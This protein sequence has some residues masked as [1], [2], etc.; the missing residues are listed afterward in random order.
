M[1]LYLKNRKNKSKNMIQNQ[2]AK[3][4]RR[5]NGISKYTGRIY[6]L[7]GILCVLAVIICAAVYEPV[8]SKAATSGWSDYP[9]YSDAQNGETLGDWEFN[10]S[11]GNGMKLGDLDFIGTEMQDGVE[12][13][14]A[15]IKTEEQLNAV[16]SGLKTSD[17]DGHQRTQKVIF[18]LT[19]DLSYS[20]QGNVV[21]Q[22][23]DMDTGVALNEYEGN[24]FEMDTFD[25][26]G[27]IIRSTVNYTVDSL[28]EVGYVGSYYG[29]FGRVNNATV[30]DL[31]V[32]LAG[33]YQIKEEDTLYYPG[34]DWN[35]T[36]WYGTTWENGYYYYL[37]IGGVCGIAEKAQ[38]LD[39]EVAGEY[40]VSYQDNNSF[41]QVSMLGLGGVLGTVQSDVTIKRCEDTTRIYAAGLSWKYPYDGY[42]IN[43]QRARVVCGIGG[44][45][46]QIVG[47]Y[48]QITACYGRGDYSYDKSSA[49]GTIQSL[50]FISSAAI[51]G[52]AGPEAAVSIKDCAGAAVS[53]SYDDI[54]DPT[55]SILGVMCD[56]SP[57][58]ITIQNCYGNGKKYEGTN[59]NEVEY[60][61]NYD[62]YLI[63]QDGE[64]FL[65]LAVGANTYPTKVE[66]GIPTLSSRTESINTDDWGY[67]GTHYLL[68]PCKYSIDLQGIEFSDP[69]AGDRTITVTGKIDGWF[70]DT[71]TDKAV[72]YL[73]VTED[74]S[75]PITS[76]THVGSQTG[77]ENGGTEADLKLSSDNT[78]YTNTGEIFTV[79]ARLKIVFDANKDTEYIWWSQIYTRSYE[80]DELFIAKPTLEVSK[81]DQVY[82]EMQSTTAYPLGTTRVKL[83]E[84]GDLTNQLLYYYFG[85]NKGMELGDVDSDSTIALN[86]MLR[87]P[88]YDEPFVIVKDMVSS[89]NS[90]QI[91]MY[92]LAYAT[93]GDEVY[94][95]L[96]E[97]D[98]VVFASDELIS[99]TPS[100][101]SKIPNGSTITFKI[102][103]REANEYPYDKVNVLISKEQN[104]YNT[105]E[106]VSGVKI[107]P[108]SDTGNGTTDDPF[109][110]AEITLTGNAGQTFYVYVEPCVNE[111][112]EQRYGSFLQEYT[113][114]IM[115][116]A[117]GPELSPSTIT[118]SQAGNPSSISIQE[119]IYMNSRGNSDIILYRIV[120]NMENK[121]I[122]PIIVTD[123]DIL[124]QLDAAQVT[125]VGENAY[126]VDQNDSAFYVRCNNIWYFM[127]NGNGELKVYEDGNLSFDASHA[128]QTAYVSVLLFAAGYDPSENLIYAYQVNEQDAVAAPTALLAS[129]SS[130]DMN[131]VLNFS[132]Q[133]N[134][135][136]FYTTNGQEP[137]VSVDADGKLSAETENGTFRYYSE[138]GIAATTENGFS[139]GAA[140][141]IKIKAYPVED[142]TADELKYNND[143]KSSAL[144]TFTYTVKEQN[145]VDTPKV[146][147]ETNT[148][149]A[150][151]VVNGDHIS[152]TC[153]TSGAEIYYTVN[154]STPLVAEEYKYPGVIEVEGDYGSY[155]TVKAMAHKEGMKDSEVATYLYKIADKDVVSGVTAI[156][157]TTNQVIAGDKIILSTTE[158]GADIYF[159]TDGTTPDVTEYENEDGTTAFTVIKGERYDPAKPVTV[160]EGSGYFMINAIA[161]KAGMTNSPVAQLIYSYADSVGVPYG[162]PSSGTVIENTQVILRCAQEDAI[163]YYEIAYDGEEPEEPT[164][165]S[166][167]FSEQA[168]IIITRDTKI[169]AFAFY[170]RESSEIVTLSYTL[171][172]K[173]EAPTSSVSSGAIVPSG[174][175][176]CLATGGGKVY[177]TTDGSDPTDSTNTAVN[178]GTDVVITG[179]PGDKIVIKAC[180]KETGATTSEM[181]TFTYQISQYPGGVATDTTVGSTL[182]G[183]TA[184]HL[185][186]DVT[187]GTIYHTTG[188]GS[189]ITAGTVG[190]SV[191]LSGEA[192]SNITV[193]AVA[194]APNTTMTG[195]Y[196]SFDYKLM[197]QL[198]AP[199]ASLKDGTKLTEK[200]SIVLKANKGKIYFTI[201]G[202]D[203]TKASN[204]YTA[205]IVVSKAMTI[206]AI[207]IEEGSENS[208][209]STFSY[210]FAEKV[211]NITSSVPSGTVVQS[212]E[213][214]KLN[215][216]TKDA[217]IYYTTDGTEPSK[218]GEEGVFVYDEKEGI[219][220]YRNVNIKAIAVK[221]ELCDSDILSLDYRVEEVPVEIAREKAAQEEEEAG[222][223]PSDITKLESRR[224]QTDKEELSDEY[225]QISDFFSNV[226]VR[227]K[228][229]VISEEST[230]RG[231]EIAVSEN[232]KKEI[233]SMLG[234]DYELICNYSFALYEN[235]ER[236]WPKGLLEI[237][238]PIPEEYENADVT[239]I[240]INEND[241]VK[242][243]STRREN[244]YVYAEV[245]YLNSYA[246]AGAKLE[247]DRQYEWNLVLIMS[248]VA[249]ALV[250]VG[251][252]MI[253]ITMVRRKR[254]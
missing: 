70:T 80:P 224:I 218:D 133:Q 241:G 220:I 234:D 172:Q 30:R 137:Q 77:H 143:K 149:N 1:S 90:N 174:T 198:A 179:K 85:K 136:M 238:I 103:N 68:H 154:G 84:N 196:A 112:Y 107:Y 121:D 187:G 101:G 86:T 247:K 212:G 245:S 252:G 42:G 14:C 39:I 199:H 13:P 155:F 118:M 230:L 248:V 189:P 236:T 115:D 28:D 16:L 214:V 119:K 82:E 2:K 206:K 9:M 213:I 37:G 190:N 228:K 185:M 76:G 164:T 59:N 160:P 56:C 130:I 55:K 24:V 54:P 165:S 11:S 159:T 254:Y 232:A 217:K 242:A 156:P 132:C 128:G 126:Y 34:M 202:T 8:W 226:T 148:E 113:Y 169:K 216:T 69:S 32:T 25:G 73:Y 124:N 229:S 135:V 23:R 162:N 225:V 110:T 249:G 75:D 195:S 180:T 22:K 50:L 106:G 49:Q 67:D 178:I 145:Q 186:T 83:T 152:L 141:I 63:A 191:V 43:Y 181:V 35:G 122:V 173:M 139:Y 95:K 102:G 200:T 251:I 120:N 51:V 52:E 3:I 79:K 6:S 131:K 127:N 167:V 215:C 253:T 64:S 246:I 94:Y 92:V 114:T 144:S 231:K 170:N 26:Q 168:P 58:N 158:S 233:Q 227:G 91:Y 237:G 53:V 96:Y 17:D 177:Y 201:D 36:T 62:F 18:K 175:T 111:E 99:V 166:A 108:D 87:Q 161:V 10:T 125:P 210:T 244:G 211:K 123:D 46:G 184:I 129:G 194:I 19:K 219:S 27:H 88:K 72:A 15:A 44:I 100:S 74:G 147:P 182:A 116:K 40:E 66:Y 20:G 222:L 204:E 221:D 153:T 240:S 157:S 45:I 207:A 203:P 4:K 57:E 117:A 197:E 41:P 192:G 134:C 142:A 60:V 38:F 31:R 205:P 223:K 93:K 21:S 47:D 65:S 104:Q 109:L 78:K 183:G 7:A 188:S 71:N 97:Y 151:V 33:T 29:L 48:N 171:A 81:E 138:N 243:Y 176:V 150:T 12:L 105:L 208:E 5:W 146:F 235:G 89:V 61:E 209:I 163:I 140:T 193:K 250:L 98:M 239:I